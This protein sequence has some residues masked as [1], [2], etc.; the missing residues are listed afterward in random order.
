MK[1]NNKPG[2]SARRRRAKQAFR[3]G[4]RLTWKIVRQF[5]LVRLITLFVLLA[6]FLV[7]YLAS[8]QY[9]SVYY[10]VTDAFQ[11]LL[12]QN[13]FNWVMEN[14]IATFLLLWGALFVLTA[15]IFSAVTLHNF[16]KTWRSLS[17]LFNDDEEI[18]S[19]SRS[20][21][22]LEIT[23]K[24]MKHEVYR[25]RMLAA[26]SEARKN[27]LVMYLAHDLK[28]PL[29][30]VIGYLSLLQES[31]E[32]STAQRA[33]YVGIALEKANR[34]EMLINEFFEITRFN[35][36][37][38]T[39]ER[40]RIDL[41]M[42]VLQ[43]ADEFYPMCRERELEISVE[44]PQR[45]VMLA[46][47]DKLARVLDNLL[48]NAVTYSYRGTVIRVGAQRRE[49]NVMIRVRNECDEI[50]PEKL[51]RLFDKFFRA[52]AARTSAS[53]GSGL[54]LAIAKQIVELHGGTI[55]AKSTPEHTDF[56]VVLPYVEP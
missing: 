52:D 21:S 5:L 43:K 35:L 54:G 19:F 39:L 32:L 9:D 12:G 11:T 40:N 28:T 2:S 15:L 7:L 56:T 25:S 34:L 23:L 31:P 16:D 42:M 38:I 6:V 27:D 33:K 4:Q 13:L 53:G 17:A 49:N 20:F 8:R 1:R 29:T 10:A 18:R 22:D 37:Q 48:K 41:G 44:I 30:S 47:A 24:D 50:S 51:A 14:K 26:E 46:D 55:T 36:Q 45:I 3:P